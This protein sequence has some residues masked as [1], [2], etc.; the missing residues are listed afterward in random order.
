MN[1][2]TT[3]AVA[4]GAALAAFTALALLDTCRHRATATIVRRD[5]VR[6]T[7]TDTV[8]EVIT[9]S[10]PATAGRTRTEYVR[11]AVHDTIAD[12]IVRAHDGEPS[13]TIP[14]TQ[15]HYRDSLYEAW[16]SGYAPR[17]DSVR[18]YTTT[19]TRTV[20]HRNRWN[21]GIQGGVGITPRGIQPYLGIGAS[22]N[23]L[24]K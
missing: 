24:E 23:F 1:H 12:T 5:T 10:Q 7:A 19:V 14:I 20:H 3:T 21:V 17:L 6:D 8:R 16:V 9:I 15:A 18:L 22:F 4:I 2:N 11:V 13:V